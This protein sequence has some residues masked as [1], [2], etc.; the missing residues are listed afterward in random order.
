M[1]SMVG[2]LSGGAQL[3]DYVVAAEIASGGMGVVY[4]ARRTEGQSRDAYAIK[5]VHDDLVKRFPGLGERLR[6]EARL[7]A[8][9][10]HPHTVAVLEIGEHASL[11]YVV[12]PYVE[13][14]TL[15]ELIEAGHAHPGIAAAVMID[16]LR[17]LHAAHIAEDERG[18]PLR[19]VHRDVC[20]DNVLVGAD[21]RGRIADFGIAVAAA[22]TLD[23][24]RG[25]GR[26]KWAFMSPE[27]LKD[28]PVDRRSDVFS[29][30]VTL[31]HALTGRG[32]FADDAVT[33]T[34]HNVLHAPVQKPSETGARPPA[35][36]D[37]VCLRALERDPEA[38]FSSADVM[39]TALREA[40]TAAGV[41]ASAEEVSA[42]VWAAVGD[43][44]SGR[45]DALDALA[46]R[47]AP[48]SLPLPPPN[49]NDRAAETLRSDEAEELAAA[50]ADDDDDEDPDGPATSIYIPDKHT[51]HDG[52]DELDIEIVSDLGPDEPS[53]A[54]GRSWLA[55]GSGEHDADRNSSELATGSGEHRALGGA[56]GE[57]DRAGADSGVA[58]PGSGDDVPSLAPPSGAL[59]RF[60]QRVWR[61]IWPGARR[62]P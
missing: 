35:A 53:S 52:H 14:G 37:Q 1:H 56:A 25:S 40:A 30:G 2:G 15:A 46:S 24:G 13:G 43:K 10:H 38:R 41:L 4:L 57:Q 58:A 21:G 48:R 19:L 62:R 22:D 12:M 47:A 20:P 60:C 59:L 33:A 23:A 61:A 18:R 28:E 54:S 11:P 17:G 6:R 29:A 5:V 7:A 27:Q 32:L 16:A 26:G 31:F 9:V 45:R 42:A 8:H 55:A 34:M 51:E 50:L 39:A 3:G 44:V 49:P 36:F